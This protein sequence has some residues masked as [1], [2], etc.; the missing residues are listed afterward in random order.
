MHARFF[1]FASLALSLLLIGQPSPTSAAPTSGASFGDTLTADTKLT[2]DLSGSGSGLIV[3]ADGIT[4]DLNG[5]SL[6]MTGGSG[7]GIDNSGGYN[8]VTVTNGMIEGF[9]E[10]VRAVDADGLKLRDLEV[11]GASGPSATTGA[12]H[13]LGGQDVTIMNSSVAVTAA[14]LGPHGIRLDSVDGVQVKNV[15]VDGSFIGISFFSVTT[16]GPNTN[17][18]IQGCTITGA[19]NYGVLLANAD[20]A[21]IQNNEI[22]ECGTG[23]WAGWNVF[24]SDMLIQDNYFH[25]NGGGF[26]LWGV[27]DSQVSG[28]TSTDNDTFGLLMRSG[29]SDNQI[30][31]NDLSYNGVRGLVLLFGANDNHISGNTVLGNGSDGISLLVGICTGNKITDNTA[32]GNGGFDLFHNA[33]STPNVWVDNAYVTKSGSDIP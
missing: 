5:Y 30:S 24:Q 4:I 6:T 14:F 25:D 8:N 2:G 17:G 12:I 13:I 19:Y 27:S 28:N 23:L 32:L 3:G 31:D 16:L 9:N 18:S 11:I 7:W 21:K 22:S 29:A 20:G 1:V 26:I 10:G 15:E 33:V